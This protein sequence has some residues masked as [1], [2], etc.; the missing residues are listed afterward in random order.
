MVRK[1]VIGTIVAI[2]MA[3]GAAACS[4]GSGC[5]GIVCND[6]WCSH[7]AN[8]QGACSSHGGIAAGNFM[9]SSAPTAP[10]SAR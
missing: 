1:F 8:R 2:G 10:S 6:G 5:D 7:A 3:L 4:G 9:V